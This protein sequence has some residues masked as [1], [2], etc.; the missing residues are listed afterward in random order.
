MLSL[1]SILLFLQVCSILFYSFILLLFRYFIMRSLLCC[2]LFMVG[3]GCIGLVLL[4][5]FLGSMGCNR[6]I[7][8]IRMILGFLL[9]VVISLMSLFL[10]G[11][12]QS[13]NVPNTIFIFRISLL[14]IW[15]I[16]QI[17]LLNFLFKN[18]SYKFLTIRD[19]SLAI[20]PFH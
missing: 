6:F 5:F 8:R 19:C 20:I 1:D 14:E 13:Y 10:D 11:D 17:F 4:I 18:V 2:R 9:S 12:I 3:V 15:R 16:L 7:A